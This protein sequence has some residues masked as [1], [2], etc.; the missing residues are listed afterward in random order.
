MVICWKGDRID[1][2]YV[3][4]PNVFQKVTIQFSGGKCFVMDAA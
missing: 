2:K 4:T 1:K 3:T